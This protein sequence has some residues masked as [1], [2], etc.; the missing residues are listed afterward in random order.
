MFDNQKREMDPEAHLSEL[1]SWHSN[2]LKEIKKPDSWLSVIGLHWLEPGENTFGSDPSNA[3]I[4]PNLPGIPARI[5]SFFLENNARVVRMVVQPE[6]KVTIEDK[7]VTSSVIFGKSKRPV[8]V[9][10]E[11]LHWQVI[12]RQDLI[13]I[14][15]RNTSN[16]AIE[17]FEGIEYFPVSINWRI[18]SRFDHYNPPRKIEVPNVLGQITMQ[19][20]PGAVVFRIGAE[21]FRLDVTG[22]PEGET[23]FIVF[24][25]MTNG[26]ETYKR[27]RFI[28][29]D[30]PDEHDRLYIDFNKA[31]NPPC[32]FTDYATCPIPPSQNRLSIRIEAGEKSIHARA[33]NQ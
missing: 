32:G 9:S 31:Y 26:K 11:S 15:L 13:G 5:G 29:V 6:V 8:T 3:V 27:G 16:P 18:P 7:P 12:K 22:D 2:R 28:T 30:A 17:A 4:F 21:E 14:R 23:F 1:K 20:S 24:G 33:N 25:D 19:R 10:L